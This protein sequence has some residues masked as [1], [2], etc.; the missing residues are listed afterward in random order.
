MNTLVGS[1]TPKGS[2]LSRNNIIEET[3]FCCDID[4]AQDPTDRNAIS[5]CHE[6]SSR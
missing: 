1:L 6:A 2:E 5:S 3:V 4:L